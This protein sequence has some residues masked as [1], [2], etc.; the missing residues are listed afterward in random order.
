MR[1]EKGDGE[2]AEARRRCNSTRRGA[3]GS[4]HKI[5]GYAKVSG[6]RDGKGKGIRKK[7]GQDH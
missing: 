2:I 5:T 3:E 1:F 6:G 7:I 4:E